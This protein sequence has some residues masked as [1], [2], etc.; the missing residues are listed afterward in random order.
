[1]FR[2]RLPTAVYTALLTLIFI[3]SLAACAPSPAAPAI[4]EASEAPQ[5][6]AEAAVQA[7]NWLVATHQN[8][9]GGY[10]AFSGGADMAPSSVPGTLDALLALAAV[11][12]QEAAI[13]PAAYLQ[14]QPDDVADFVSQG[15]GNAG[16]VLVALTAVGDSPRE[17]GGYNLVI[18]STQQ[19][20]PT[21]QLNATTA[22]NQAWAIVGLHAAGEPIPPTAVAWL[23]D[24]QTAAGSWSDGFGTDDN[25][26]A[27][28][29]AMMALV[30]AGGEAEALD[31][32]VGFL[33]AAQNEDGGWGY[34]SGS[35]SN[36]NSS[37]LAIQALIALGE[38]VSSS[39][40]TWAK[41]GVAP[42]DVLL[43]FQS[44]NGAFQADFGDGPFDDFYATV[45]A[46]PAVAGQA[47]PLVRE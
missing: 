36:P 46:L 38:D 23:T 11:E 45:Q 7:V 12:G 35:P 22:Y 37:A 8:E 33:R 1:M 43:S 40:S 27:T 14:S 4:P 6:N 32:A 42:L 9:D 30:A 5:G 41:A 25:P 13:A 26:D 39:E 31:T 47:F 19:L 34:T 15:G 18:S 44:D 21:G 20:S 3:F 16:K 17:F 24:Q 29:M 10:T 28:G 2:F